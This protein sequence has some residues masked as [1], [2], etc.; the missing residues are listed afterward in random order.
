MADDVP[1]WGTPDG[2]SPT[3]GTSKPGTSDHRTPDH[4]S[5]AHGTPAHGTPEH[6]GPGYGTSDHGTPAD[7]TPAHGTPDHGTPD[8]GTPDHGTPD[9]GTPDYG[10]PQPAS[11]PRG[12]QGYGA[13]ASPGRPAPDPAATGWGASLTGPGLLTAA[14]VVVV[15]NAAFLSTGG[16][17]L[18][19]AD[20]VPLGSLVAETSA[21]GFIFG[22]AATTTYRLLDPRNRVLGSMVRPGT[23]GRSRFDVTGAGGT[24]IGTVE[25]ENSFG[26]PVLLLTT[27][28]G[29]LM[30]LSG[31]RFGS[32]EWQL[33]DG[34]D[35][36][37]LMGQVSQEYAGLSGMINDTHRFAVQLSPQ[38]I[39]DHRLLAV[40][41]TVC[42]D[43][44]RDAKKG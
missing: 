44:I 18:T 37:V 22:R 28:D 42:L 20:D 14:T 40:M 15:E 32:R 21:A 2:D 34:L 24:H 11:A 7:G 8:H 5:P 38:L 12:R 33:V 41:A 23:L 43:H 19:D 29:L 1:P 4:G 13:P 31:G 35:E 39:G 6:S 10:T 36:S 30:R 25:Q 27:A 9:Y 3:P 26:A 16:Y 17:T